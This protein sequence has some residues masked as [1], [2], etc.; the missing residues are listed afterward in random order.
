MRAGPDSHLYRASGRLVAYM[1]QDS[2]SLCEF[3]LFKKQFNISISGYL[4]V[5]STSHRKR[6]TG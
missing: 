3:L 2:V 1:G 6:D 4:S 5:Q